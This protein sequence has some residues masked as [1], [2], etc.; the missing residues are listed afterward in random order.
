MF[1]LDLIVPHVRKMAQNGNLG[2]I[3]P[4]QV[5]GRVPVTGLIGALLIIFFQIP[6]GWVQNTGLPILRR[7][8]PA[9]LFPFGWRIVPA[10]GL[11]TDWVK[12]CRS[13]IGAGN[14]G[15][16]CTSLSPLFRTCS[17]PLGQIGLKTVIGAQSSRIRFLAAS[18]SP[19]LL[20]HF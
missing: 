11:G 4:Y 18:R 9:C 17:P 1:F 20:G 3:Q 13:W 6:A 16:N 5:F 15:L 7:G 10:M 2:S 19:V 12:E 14:A 8:K